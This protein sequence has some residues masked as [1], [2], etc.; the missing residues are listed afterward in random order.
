[1]QP[2]CILRLRGA[3]EDSSDQDIDDVEVGV[4]FRVSGLGFRV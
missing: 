3:Q 4:G 1:M 2:T